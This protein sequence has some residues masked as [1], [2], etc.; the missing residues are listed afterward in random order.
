MN[1][2]K[3]ITIITSV[4]KADKLIDNY[5]KHITRLN[6]FEL[7]QLF[8][9]DIINSHKNHL[10]IEKIITDYTNGYD[11]IEH[12][13]IEQDPGLY[14][15]WNMGVIKSNTEFI[16]NAN[17][18]DFRHPDYL[19]K[20]LYYM[21]KNIVDLYSSNYYTT[22]Q[23]PTNWNDI[24]KIQ[25]NNQTS[26]KIKAKYPTIN[27]QYLYTYKDMFQLNKDYTYTKNCYP[28]CAPVWRRALHMIDNEIKI[29]FDE[30]QYGACADYEFWIRSCKYHHSTFLLDYNPLILYYEGENNHGVIGKLK[31][32][33]LENEI[34][35]SQIYRYFIHKNRN[36]YHSK[37]KLINMGVHN[38][39]NIKIMSRYKD[40]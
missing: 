6:G 3:K 32:K 34:L 30:D 12:I 17:L 27:N 24:K 26:K 21:D 19:I 38:Y 13:K 2:K 33:E 35:N 31:N 40:N 11:N 23:L 10:Y 28:H 16:T 8:L 9:Y 5:L 22:K 39:L 4:F 15:I 7:C 18:D 25:I 1:N 29:L 20:A 36:K 37:N 14:E